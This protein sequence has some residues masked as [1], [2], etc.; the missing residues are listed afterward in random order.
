MQNHHVLYGESS[1]FG[2]HRVAPQIAQEV[3]VEIGMARVPGDS[4][5]RRRPIVP[6]LRMDSHNEASF[7]ALRYKL[8][9]RHHFSSLIFLLCQKLNSDQNFSF[10]YSII[11]KKETFNY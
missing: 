8:S 7:R 2:R 4:V 3:L 1:L 11:F 5:A 9:K 10:V 6:E